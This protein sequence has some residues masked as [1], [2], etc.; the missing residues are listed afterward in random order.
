M[1]KADIDYSNTII[2]KIYCKDDNIKEL[3]VGH[4]TNF[5]Q[6]KYSHKIA[7]NNV[8]NTQKIYNI[9]RSNGGWGNWDMIE[10]AKYC[11]KDA[12]EARIKEQYHYDELKS[13]LNSVCAYIDKTSL[14]CSKCNLQCSS[15][16]Q[17]NVH[18]LS[19]KHIKND[20]AD[21]YENNTK[22]SKISLKYCCNICDFSSSNKNDYNRHNLTN[23]HK[24]NVLSTN[25]NTESTNQT[26]ICNICNK[27][28][29]ERSGLWRHKKKCNTNSDISDIANNV[30]NVL[31]D[32]DI[33]MALMKD[34]SDFKAMLIDIIN[35][36]KIDTKVT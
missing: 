1:P 12:T 29:K 8:N 36:L 33:I 17:Y 35:I 14:F 20:S 22:T 4:T 27:K 30:Q 31:N 16:N 25:V 19:Q 9:I 7:C 18:I 2:Y 11:C 10:I 24:I 32:K 28:Y 15:P 3:Y 23:K 21:N 34:N 13:S 5:I 6:R 26:H